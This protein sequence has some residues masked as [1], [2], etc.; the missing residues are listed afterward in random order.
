MISNLFLFL[1]RL[2]ELFTEELEKKLSSLETKIIFEKKDRLF[3][4][5]AVNSI[6]LFQISG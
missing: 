3:L 4:S 5:N 6:Q 2:F 1:F